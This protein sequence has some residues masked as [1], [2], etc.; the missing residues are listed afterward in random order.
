MNT[1]TKQILVM[2]GAGYIGSHTVRQVLP[3]EIAEHRPGDPARLFAN[4]AA[5]RSILGWQPHHTD[6]RS[7]LST[8]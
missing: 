1:E 5:A 8:A 3:H 6:I 2:G 7:I 4:N